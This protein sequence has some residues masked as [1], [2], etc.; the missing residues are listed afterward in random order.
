MT[1]TTRRMVANR[2]PRS[3]EALVEEVAEV[4]PWAEGNRR[5]SRAQEYWLATVHPDGRPHVRPV[6]AVWVDGAL[7]S[8]T[9]PRTRK[10]RNLVGN[11][12]CSLTLRSEGIDLVYEGSATRV[13]DPARLQRAAAGYNAKYEWP[14]TV[15]DG[16]FDAPYGAPTAGP[17]PYDVYEITPTAVFA[18]GTDETFAP[19]STCWRW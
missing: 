3:A 9:G 12:R 13:S 17:L 1:G 11:P 16:A 5:L 19:R 15:L 7:H 4:L 14:A 10:G 8:T 6:L 18:F 2:E